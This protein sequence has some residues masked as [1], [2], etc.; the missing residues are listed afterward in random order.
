M[1]PPRGGPPPSPPSPLPALFHF[2]LGRCVRRDPVSI[3]LSC[4]LVPFLDPTNKSHF[5]PCVCLRAQVKRIFTQSSTVLLN[6]R[7]KLSFFIRKIVSFIFLCELFY[8]KYEFV[9]RFLFVCSAV[10]TDFRESSFMFFFIFCYLPGGT[11]T[12]HFELCNTIKFL[13]HFD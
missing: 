6:F 4:L 5:L 8:L 9:C 2:P 11:K 10:V 3:R 12:G 7:D 13:C 1:W